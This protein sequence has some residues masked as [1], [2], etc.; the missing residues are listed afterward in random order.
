MAAP[1][2]RARG[3]DGQRGVIAPA[4][5]E[6]RPAD[7]QPPAAIGASVTAR[8]L[9]GSDRF[10][11]H[12]LF[13]FGSAYPEVVGG[14]RDPDPAPLDHGDR[15][16]HAIEVLTVQ[17]AEQLAERHPLLTA[18]QLGC[19]LEQQPLAGPAAIPDELL[20]LAE[21]DRPVAGEVGGGERRDPGRT[22]TW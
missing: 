18:V 21:I 12:A 16:E 8:S 3:T 19:H 13:G 9:P 17:L 7:P 5:R 10:R 11:G 4:S 1:S 20:K 2:P 6:P 15:I 22:R 14:S